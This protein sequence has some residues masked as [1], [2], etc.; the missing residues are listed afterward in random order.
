MPIL[1]CEH[2]LQLVQLVPLLFGA[3]PVG[4][5]PKLLQA[6]SSRIRLRLVHDRYYLILG[7]FIGVCNAAACGARR[8]ESHPPVVAE[9]VT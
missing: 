4:Y 1:G 8:S 2:D 5:C 9:L 7:Q 6:R 3:I